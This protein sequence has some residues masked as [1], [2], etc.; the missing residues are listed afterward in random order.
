MQSV[1]CERCRAFSANDAERSLRAMKSVLCERC[2]A[3]FANDA[4]RSLRT[5][6]SVLCERCRVFFASDVRASFARNDRHVSLRRR[7]VPEAIFPSPFEANYYPKSSPLFPSKL[8]HSG[9]ACRC[10]WHSVPPDQT[11]T[12]PPGWQPNPSVASARCTAKAAAW[13]FLP[14]TL[15][16]CHPARK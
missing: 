16:G 7:F 3:F 1:L 11:P 9:A 15:F 10:A 13:G 12:T 6:Q 2:R 8:T 14:V 4:E 5:M